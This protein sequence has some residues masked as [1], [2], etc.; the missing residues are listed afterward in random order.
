MPLAKFVY[1]IA[2]AT[3]LA[4]CVVWQN[5]GLRTLGYRLQDLR[6]EIAEQ[7]AEG[8]IYLAHLSKLSNPQRIAGLIAWLGLDLGTHPV[9]QAAPMP[10]QSTEGQP[11]AARA[12]SSGSDTAPSAPS[13][14]AGAPAT[15][16]PVGRRL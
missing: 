4:L 13:Q 12:A 16:P 9:A 10:R 5:A 14:P 6:E 7:E 15:S 11:R 3:A 1:G 8:A 2:L